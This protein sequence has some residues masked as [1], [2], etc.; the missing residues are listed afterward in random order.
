MR[1]DP[2]HERRPRPLLLL[3]L[4]VSLIT[5]GIGAASAQAAIS[6]YCNG[7]YL[8]SPG[9]MTC[10]ASVSWYLT[11]NEVAAADN[12]NDSV[13]AGA[14]W[15]DGTFY[16]SYICATNWACHTYGGSNAL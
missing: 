12:S 9:H 7:A 6:S 11:G 3:A 4:L 14:G 16:G 15:P 8:Y 13:C 5:A 10:I 1:M 2:H